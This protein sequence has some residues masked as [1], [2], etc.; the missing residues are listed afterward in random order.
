[1][2]L[3]ALSKGLITSFIDQ[4]SYS[5]DIYQTK[6]VQN[7]YP[8]EKVINT[9][10]GELEHCTRFWFTTA[11]LSMSG[12]NTLYSLLENLQR[13]NVPGRILVS[14]YLNFT[15]PDAL[16][17]LKKFKNIEVRIDT[18][19][20]LHAKTYIFQR[21]DHISV[22]LGSSN[23]TANA[24]SKNEELNIF[25]RALPQSKIMRDMLL[26][27]KI[28]QYDQDVIEVE[29]FQH[30]VKERYQI[31][32]SKDDLVSILN[33]L[34]MV[35]N[36]TKYFKDFDI[37][38][39]NRGFVYYAKYGRKDVFRILNWE[40]NQNPQN[41]GGYLASKDKS[42]C[43]IFVTYHK[44][45][46]ISDSTKYED[47]FIDP[48][49]FQWMSKSKRKISSPDV[50]VILNAQQQGTLLPLFVK[51]DDDEGVDFYF[52]GFLNYIEGSAQETLMQTDAGPVSVV[53][54]DFRINKPVENGLYKYL[55]NI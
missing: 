50:Q 19:S 12:F 9:F 5:E 18:K 54:I 32:V 3:D 7:N 48:Q 45:D 16:K 15:Q 17:R 28:I 4:S 49:H 33:N 38:K 13:R 10:E 6:L 51:K 23:L 30:E 36:P 37:V 39:F 42:N 29:T 1:M 53:K 8:L 43:P 25:I 46:D 40:K 27:K 22:L 31:S 2:I 21:E 24:L 34:N 35:F 52:I 55:V 11:F 20:D 14:Q 47:K 44:A 41:V 26:K